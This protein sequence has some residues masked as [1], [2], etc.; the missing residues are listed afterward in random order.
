MLPCPMPPV[1]HSNPIPPKYRPD[2][3]LSSW[4]VDSFNRRS[5][6]TMKRRANQTTHRPTNRPTDQPIKR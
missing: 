1:S 2:D 5:D 6:N 4:R 3:G